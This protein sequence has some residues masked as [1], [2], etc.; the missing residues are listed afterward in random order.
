MSHRKAAVDALRPGSP[1][2]NWKM[3]QSDAMHYMETLEMVKAFTKKKQD[4]RHPMGALLPALAADPRVRRI[5][6]KL[7]KTTVTSKQNAP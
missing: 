7:E 4:L 5:H 3:G 6:G 2:S 1:Q